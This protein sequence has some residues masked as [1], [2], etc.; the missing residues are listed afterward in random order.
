VRGSDIHK[1]NVIRTSDICSSAELDP[2]IITDRVW[3]E[4]IVDEKF[5]DSIP[6]TNGIKS[7]KL[8]M[9]SSYL[10]ALKSQYCW[11]YKTDKKV[12]K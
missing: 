6:Q 9:K 7:A 2:Q 12:Q 4:M 10:E 5:R 11:R 8:E 3:Y 1:Y